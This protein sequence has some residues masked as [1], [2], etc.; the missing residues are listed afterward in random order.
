MQQIEV[1][2]FDMYLEKVQRSEGWGAVFR[3][4]NHAK[5]EAERFMDYY[6]D[7]QSSTV[8]PIELHMAAQRVQELE[9]LAGDFCTLAA[10]ID[11]MASSAHGHNLTALTSLPHPRAGGARLEEVLVAKRA[12]L[13]RLLQETP[14]NFTELWNVGVSVQQLEVQLFNLYLGEIGHNDSGWDAA[15]DV[16]K[17]AKQ[18]AV[19]NKNFLAVYQKANGVRRINF[20]LAEK[21]VAE[22]E[23]LNNIK[24]MCE[25]GAHIQELEVKLFALYLDEIQQ[26]KGSE[27]ADKALNEAKQ[28][29][30]QFR[31]FFSAPARL[32]QLAY[33]VNRI[34]NYMA[35]VREAKLE[36]L[37]DNMADA[38][39]IRD[40]VNVIQHLEVKLF[41][42]RLDT[43]WR[44]SGREAAIKELKNVMAETARL[45][46][47]FEHQASI[48]GP[49]R[50]FL[51]KPVPP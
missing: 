9:E 4:L 21:L 26:E 27:S 29:A 30:K 43:T 14:P 15:A 50:L 3:A 48:S 22:L 51:P 46:E 34:N 20:I 13:E 28:E 47:G 12:T 17:K 2:L 36:N 40:L 33:P 16:L 35:G 24:K 39:K 11:D 18:D 25:V 10:H 31:K 19:H 1:W 38:M 5:K 45:E 49:S 7:T 6:K 37:T 8:S 23:K 32:G 42:S 41:E 44:T